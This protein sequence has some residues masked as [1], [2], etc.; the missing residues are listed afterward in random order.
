MGLTSRPAQRD[1]VQGDGV[2]PYLRQDPNEY[3]L[4]VTVK[5]RGVQYSFTSWFQVGL[6]EVA[7][8]QLI[9]GKGFLRDSGIELYFAASDLWTP[10]H[11]TPTPALPAP[12]PMNWPV[13]AQ[14][15]R[16][17]PQVPRVVVC[18]RCQG[19]GHREAVC[20]SAF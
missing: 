1:F 16:A 11:S 8:H 10:A 13:V 7:A 15:V 9:L 3:N 4:C 12:P 20:P 19:R 14:A 17:R 2:T 5:L 18:R 6:M